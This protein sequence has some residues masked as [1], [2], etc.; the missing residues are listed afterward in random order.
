MTT[1]HLIQILVAGFGALALLRSALFIVRSG[2]Q[3]IPV[4]FATFI[5]VGLDAADRSV[6]RTRG[7]A[8]STTV[9]RLMTGVSFAEAQYSLPTYC[10]ALMQNL[11]QDDQQKFARQ[12]AALG[13]AQ[14]DEN[15]IVLALGLAIMNVMGEDVLA[16]AIEALGQTIKS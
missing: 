5:Q 1:P 14:M 4:G 13:T 9:A 7:R 8:R 16:S 6:D 15:A 10:L 2:D 11:S 3:D 12:I